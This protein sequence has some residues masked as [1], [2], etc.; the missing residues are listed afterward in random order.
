MLE[1]M[2]MNRC[3]DD[4]DDLRLRVEEMVNSDTSGA[5]DG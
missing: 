4:G 2:A 1:K 3:F 5:M